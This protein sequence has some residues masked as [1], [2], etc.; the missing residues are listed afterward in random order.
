MGLPTMKAHWRQPQPWLLFAGAMALTALAVLS[1]QRA[2]H[3]HRAA[4]F[5]DAVAAAEA[6]LRAQLEGYAAL[7]LAT[8]AHLE[9]AVVSRQSFADFVGG[10]QLAQR[11]PGLR[12]IGWSPRLAT[13]Q[14][15]RA[16]EASA[17]TEG[18]FDYRVWADDGQT[19]SFAVRY[20][21]PLDRRNS[22]ALGYDM[23]SEPVRREA[24]QRAASS[25][26]LAMSGA[27]VLKQELASAGTPGFLLYLP[28]YGQRRPPGSA[29]ER[30]AS[31][32]GF[33][34]SAVRA[35]DFFPA[36]FDT[37]RDA[38]AVRV[39]DRA[40]STMVL[41]DN[42]GQQPTTAHTRQRSFDHA[43][44]RWTLHF[45]AL[46]ALHDDP[47]DQRLPAS[48]G[49]AGVLTSLGLLWLAS[50]RAQARLALHAADAAREAALAQERLQRSVAESLSRVALQ[51][52]AEHDAAQAVQRVTDEATRLSGA[53]FGAY[54]RNVPDAQ[55]R[56]APYTLSGAALEDFGF[57]APL[58]AT[59]LL[60]ATFS[61]RTVRLND[62]RHSPLLSGSATER[63]TPQGERPVASFLGV[64]VR[65]RS[66]RVLG[67]LFLGHPDPDRFQAQHAQLVEGLAAQAGVVL[68]NLE[69]LASE[70]QAR[71]VAEERK[72]LLDLVI[73]QSGDGIVV[74]DEAGVLRIFN[75]AAQRQHGVAFQEVSAPDWQTA[76]RL[77]T[78]DGAPLRLSATPLYHALQGTAVDHARW[79]VH[80]PDGT[81]RVL[82]GS[83]EPLRR[84]DGSS[85][86]AALI[87]RDET[88]R[89][90][91]EEERT[92]L[93]DA[94][95]RSN[96]E[97]DQFAYVAS[98]DLKAP[99]RGIGNLA[100]WVLEDMEGEPPAK[101]KAHLDMMRGR[102]QR[103]EALIDGILAYSRAGRSRSAGQPVPVTEVLQE[104]LLLLAPPD[105][106][107]VEATTPLP[108][109]WGERTALQQVL[110]NLVG[111]AVKH[112]IGTD[113]RIQVR[114]AEHD[115]HWQVTVQ[116]NGPGV[117]AQ[118][119]ERIWGMFQTLQ[120]R[121]RVEGTG[122]GLAVVRKIIQAHGGR[123]WVESEPGNGAAFHFTW[124][125]T[126]EGRPA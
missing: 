16:L 105:T 83:A 41:F 60:A 40:P 18:L 26:E 118:Y 68:E 32:V 55:G 115:D 29:D 94:L 58:R 25:G 98:H 24:M 114:A 85:A 89:L 44:H 93:I 57:F 6:R 33:A 117:A 63:D 15:A 48:V 9:S 39:S 116:D 74:A 7:L 52:S 49:M 38:L 21:A 77:H 53:A 107:T 36:I 95:G 27:V 110:L 122:I 119:H 87:I 92:R 75:P 81:W 71:R 62:V 103:M 88:E 121:D 96:R 50:R 125:K 45:T 66:G 5:D 54:F 86:G 3:S 51:L 37:A 80:R 111:N 56:Y 69:L 113:T 67:G 12:S 84:A 35:V 14:D 64:C 100:Q 123:T 73:E 90:A 30:R 43:G 31:L 61:G 109:L 120:S 4:A 23:S 65:S 42:Q 124:P 126:A 91:A 20:L 78:M 102:I 59:A 72:Q 112:G 10:L 47:L 2:V 46:P 106:V 13:P 19:P 99:L 17:R 28:L 22:A 108:V 82:T 8:R 101:V 34:Y 70:R 97:L 79:R 104:V 1:A 11:Y 76:Y